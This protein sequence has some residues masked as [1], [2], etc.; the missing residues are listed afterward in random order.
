MTA[1]VLHEQNLFLTTLI[2]GVML[3][4]LLVIYNRIFLWASQ[5][6][7]LLGTFQKRL[8]FWYMAFVF[9][10]PLRWACG[11]TIE[12]AFLVPTLN[13]LLVAM[14]VFTAIET[15]LT[16]IFKYTENGEARIPRH[17][18]LSVRLLIY[19][20]LFAI[21]FLSF[22]G[23]TIFQSAALYS[24]LSVFMLYLIMHVTYTQFFNGFSGITRSRWPSAKG[25]GFSFTLR[26]LSE[27]HFTHM[28]TSTSSD[29]SLWRCTKP[30][31][32]TFTSHFS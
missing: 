30:P 25:S 20:I 1:N 23:Q 17:L 19:G 27:W 29:R 6:T 11:N 4:A 32:L 14:A 10:I 15:I 18:R 8:R 22:E 12:W 2:T 16:L 5:S 24:I 7:G 9:L 26:C 31:I 21:V 13:I 28:Q 3:V